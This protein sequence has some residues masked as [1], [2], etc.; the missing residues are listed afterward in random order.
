[1]NNQG[2]LLLGVPLRGWVHIC[3]CRRVLRFFRVPGGRK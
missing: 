1:M 3:T 2:L